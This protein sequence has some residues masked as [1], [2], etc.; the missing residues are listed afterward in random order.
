MPSQNKD[1]YKILGVDKKASDEEIKSAYRKLAKMYHPD[2][3]KEPGA[4]EKFKEIS[5]AY[6]VL[7]DKTKRSNYDQFGSADGFSGG[8]DPRRD[9]LHAARRGHDAGD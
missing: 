6:G 7:S 4:A 1:Y 9:F 3:N 8:A 5:E 2:V